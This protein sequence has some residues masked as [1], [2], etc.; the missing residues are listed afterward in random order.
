MGSKTNVYVMGCSAGLLS[1]T[2]PNETMCV[3][4][5]LTHL[6]NIVQC[7]K[8]HCQLV[9]VTGHSSFLESNLRL[10]VGW[11]RVELYINSAESLKYLMHFYH[12]HGW[13]CFNV[14]QQSNAWWKLKTIVH[15]PLVATQ[16]R[17]LS[18]VQ[19]AG[20]KGMPKKWCTFLSDVNSC[21]S[22]IFTQFAQFPG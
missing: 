11:P 3:W 21:F 17:R 15:C 2:A 16:R 1:F 8:K 10:I 12:S 7:L 5:S 19:L 22:S 6:R 13:L 9:S 4:V 14:F 20:H 18:W